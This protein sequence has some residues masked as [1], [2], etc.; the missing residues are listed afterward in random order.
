MKSP[1]SESDPASRAASPPADVD[2]D[3]DVDRRRAPARWHAWIV[4]IAVLLLL[5]L[6]VYGFVSHALQALR[7]RGAQTGFDFLLSP[8]GFQIG[9]GWLDF[10]SDQPFWRAFLAGF[11]NT[12]RAAVPAAILAIVIG[13]LLG[14]GRLAPHALIRGICTFYV[15]LIRNIPLL[16]QLLLTYFVITQLL[17]AATEALN[18]LPGVWLSKSGLSIPWPVTESGSWWPTSIDWPE[19]ST[20]NVSGGAAVTPEY[21]AIVSAL[22]FYT[23]AFVAEVVR[24]GIQ[25]VSRGQKDSAMA[26]GLSGAQQ[27]RIVILPQAL[28]V[29]VPSLTNQLLNLTKNSSLAVAVG[30]PDLVSIANTSINQTGRAFECIAVIMGVYLALSL[31]ISGVMNLYNRRVALKGWQ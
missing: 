2:V 3:V 14:I 28:R 16:V 25:S 6:C 29:I 24:A 1:R 17:P 30:Y 20:F 7:E 21:L 4:Q 19:L 10:D 23:A 26:L 8:A 11:A 22:G 13:T 18:P 31:L 5:A 27:M 9:E 12:I 15:E